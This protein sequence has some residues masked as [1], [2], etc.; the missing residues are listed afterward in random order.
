MKKPTRE[1]SALSSLKINGPVTSVLLK[2][3][4]TTIFSIGIPAMPEYLV[5]IEIAVVVLAAQGS[6][7]AGSLDCA[8]AIWRSHPPRI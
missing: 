5:I 2:R 7:F 3:S 6:S 1:P 4:I 8:H